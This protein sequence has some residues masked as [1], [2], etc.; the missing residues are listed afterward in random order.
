[1]LV[2]RILIPA[3]TV[4]GSVLFAVVKVSVMLI[5]AQIVLGWRKTEMDVRKSSIWEVRGQICFM[6]RESWDRLVLFLVEAR[7]RLIEFV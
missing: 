2:P 1:M 3:L 4:Q 5:T 6:R 7:P